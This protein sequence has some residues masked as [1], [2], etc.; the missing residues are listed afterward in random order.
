MDYQ[1]FD[2]EIFKRGFR[3]IENHKFRKKKN[4]SKNKQFFWTAY[5]RLLKYALRHPLHFFSALLFTLMS[6]MGGIIL[7]YLSGL[8]MNSIAHKNFDELLEN[9][10]LYLA[11]LLISSISM[12]FRT[13]LLVTISD[14]VS[15]MLKNDAFEK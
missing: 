13:L 8:V 12:F 9:C 7:P 4:D 3:T 1:Q 2:Q 6:Q 14:L 5:S 10:L 11:S 15:N